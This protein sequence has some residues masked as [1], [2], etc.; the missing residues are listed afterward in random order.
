M[1]NPQLILHLTVLIPLIYIFLRLVEV[2]AASGGYSLPFSRGRAVRRRGHSS[3]WRGRIRRLATG[4]FLL[5]EAESRPRGKPQGSSGGG[6]SRPPSWELVREARPQTCYWCGE[7]L[8]PQQ[9]VHK[10]QNRLVID[11]ERVDRGLVGTRTLW[12]VQ[13]LRCP[14]CGQLVS[15]GDLVNAPKHHRFGYGLMAYSLHHRLQAKQTTTDI[16]DELQF[17]LAGDAPTHQTVRNWVGESATRNRQL[18]RELLQLAKRQ[19]Y[20]QVDEC[21]L[22]LD[23]SRWW[24]WVISARVITLYLASPTRGHQAV[25]ELLRDYLGTLVVDFCTPYEKLP[26]DKQRCL[27][28]LYLEATDLLLKQVKAQLKLRGQ[29]HSSRRDRRLQAPGKRSR[30]RPRRL[31]ILSPKE[32][33]IRIEIRERG[34]V[35]EALYQVARLLLQVMAGQVTSQ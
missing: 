27:V 30:G 12:R 14:G 11:L 13:W 32:E 17:I 22:P 34:G 3:R 20:L 10:T 18:F 7:T 8:S 5:E 33:E 16:A 24:M 23:G 6:R 25:E 19:G 2:L 29:L 31:R 9:G 35:A 4:R 28:H 21:G 15:G 1:M 26:Q